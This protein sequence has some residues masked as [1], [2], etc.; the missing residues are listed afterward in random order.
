MNIINLTDFIYVQSVLFLRNE[1]IYGFGGTLSGNKKRV[2]VLMKI[3]KK[4]FEIDGE[5]KTSFRMKYSVDTVLEDRKY[6]NEPVGSSLKEVVDIEG[7]KFEMVCK[8]LKDVGI[9]E[10]K[11]DYENESLVFIME[12]KF[13]IL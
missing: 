13:H 11:I 5:K 3:F 1:D 10:V 12:E 6:E 4:I 9:T 7:Y 8:P 2:Y